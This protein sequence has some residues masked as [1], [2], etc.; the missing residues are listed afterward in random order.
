M[1]AVLPCSCLLHAPRRARNFL[2]GRISTVRAVRAIQPP[3]CPLLHHSSTTITATATATSP[4]TPAPGMLALRR[5]GMLVARQRVSASARTAATALRR[6]VGGV[7]AGGVAVG[8]CAACVALC[9]NHGGAGSP[10][11]CPELTEAT[12]RRVVSQQRLIDYMKST[13]QI[14]GALQMQLKTGSLGA[15]LEEA[16]KVYWTRMRELQEE[17]ALETQ[18]ILYGVEEKGARAA[19]EAEFGCVRWTES[20]LK[21]LVG[22]SP[23]RP[24]LVCASLYVCNRLGLNRR[25]CCLV[26]HSL[27]R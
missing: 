1:P 2:P 7:F 22:L 27:W 4:S 19:Y 24:W 20:A 12:E 23:V 16:T 9:Q 6:R 11:V 13:Q 17:V 15:S 18:K 5:P 21:I 25:R 26:P 8:T 14:V 3:Y 10:F